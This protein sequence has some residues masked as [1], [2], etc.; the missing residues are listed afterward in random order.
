VHEEV[1]VRINN[2]KETGLGHVATIQKY[3]QAICQASDMHALIVEG[4]PGWGKTTAVE[5]ALQLAG[6]ESFHL[7]SYST[8]LHLYNFLEEHSKK[9]ILLDDVSGIFTDQSAMALLKAATWPSRDGKRILRWGSTS[10]K[11]SAPEFEFSGKLV[12]VCNS[13]PSTSDGEAVRSRGYA[14]RIDISLDEAK[15]LLLQASQD[16]Q[17]FPRSDLASQVAKFLIRHL[18]ESTLP[19]IS[20]RTLKKGYRLAE[21]HSD[22]W[23][24][25]F[26]AIL[27]TR[28]IL[29]EKLVHELSRGSLQV[30]EQA[31]IFQERTGLKI[32]SFYNYR[33]DAQ[34]SRTVRG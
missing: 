16:T 5:K 32:R 2:P 15:R 26:Q 10:A 18:D 24:D 7:A 29:P 6:V 17:Q 27:P 33:R 8:P 3:I 30:K 28:A 22:S 20:F 13:F 12:I 11:A 34:L 25:L 19:Q 14:K 4:R 1:S 21:V 23:Q 31:R 9:V